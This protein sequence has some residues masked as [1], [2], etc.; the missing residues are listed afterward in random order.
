MNPRIVAATGLAGLTLL[1]IAL[2]ALAPLSENSSAGII[3]VQ[4]DSDCSGQVGAEDALADLQHAADVI[5]SAECT[6]AAGDVDCDEDVD[7]ED[8]VATIK[9]A[10][11]FAPDAAA[12]GADSCPAI[13]EPLAT[14]T[15]TKTPT[16][17]PTPTGTQPPS[18]TTTPS[19]S[20]TAT[21]TQGPDCSG[22]GG[23]ATLP[24]DPVGSGTPSAG[25]YDTTQ[26]AGLS[27]AN[28]GAAADSAIE[29][30]LMPGHPNVAIIATQDGRL[31]R[32]ELD[33][34]FTV[35]LWGDI[36]GPNLTD[37]GEEGLLSFAFSPD[38]END[39]RVYLY[40]T[41]GAPDPTIL[42]RFSA[43]PNGLDESSEEVLLQVEEFAGNHNGGH[44]AF[45]D[46]AYLYLSI[47]DGGG[48][49][50]PR[51]RGQAL[52]TLLG[53][54]IR[55]DVSGASGYEIPAGNPF[56]GVG[57]MCTT[58][59]APPPNGGPPCEEIFAYGF[60][61][62][63]RMTIDP[64]TDEVWLGDVGQ[65]DWEEVDNVIAGGNYGW[66]CREG[67]HDYVDDDFSESY[68]DLPCD[69]PFLPARAEYYHDFGQA[70]TGGVIYRGDAMPELYGWYLYADFYTGR[71]WAVD[72]ESSAAAIELLDGGLNIPAFTLAADG[73][74]YIVS[75][76]DGIYR[77]AP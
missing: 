68:P 49:G 39:C 19:Q 26:V 15:P 31:W 25:T 35:Q 36:R 44:I 60:R 61:N 20:P 3:L 5:S 67:N 4:G 40:Y 77:L 64:V 8:A 45:D 54:V 53:K 73:E 34:S 70:V 30:A 18:V 46:A 12:A 23:G 16:P 37:G 58:P 13:G 28:L 76:S 52:N 57:Q 41:P 21:P 43:T 65:G 66:D 47:G 69:G 72:T 6:E 10:A 29:L 17:T 38:F 1:V 63:F 22:P 11:G 27:A 2:L 9:Y 55:I 14:A 24:G 48:S 62:P 75:Y 74:V 51:E 59:T 50:D 56:S 32:V 7:V 71:I 42:S 33:G